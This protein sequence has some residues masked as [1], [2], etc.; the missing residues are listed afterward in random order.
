MLALAPLLRL[1]LAPK[2]PRTPAPERSWTVTLHR[3]EERHELRV[4]E[5][6]S[7][8]E[9]AEQAG[10]LPGCHCRRG[11]CLSCAAR[12]KAGP[13]FVLQVAEDTALC[14]EADTAGIVLLC[15]AFPCGPGLEL[16]LEAEG[17][18]LEIQYY[19]RFQPAAKPVVPREQR[20]PR[21]HFYMPDDLVNHLER[22]R[23]DASCS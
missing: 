7:V 1:S 3:G 9:A 6:R 5:T 15:S 18:A 12:V 21:P 4:P 20:P 17:D 8:L 11:R 14:E 22:C 10:L 23:L 16:E 19:S 13:P 2:A